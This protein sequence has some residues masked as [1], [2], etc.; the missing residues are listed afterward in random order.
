ERLLHHC[1]F[2]HKVQD[3]D[4]EVESSFAQLS[5]HVLWQTVNR[6][7]SAWHHAANVRQVCESLPLHSICKIRHQIE[8]RIECLCRHLK[9]KGVWHV[10]SLNSGRLARVF[11]LRG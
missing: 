8:D 3:L 10:F 4:A 11:V 2:L 5:G 9:H 1:F 7:V 6:I